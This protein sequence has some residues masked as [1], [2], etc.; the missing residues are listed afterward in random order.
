[1]KRSLLVLFVAASLATSLTARPIVIAH[2]GA[3]GYLPE[4]T[5]EAKALA[6]AMGADYI[7]QDVVLTQDGTPI[8]LHDIELDSTTDVAQR[9]PGRAREDGHYYAIDFTLAEIRQ[10]N[11]HERVDTATGQPVFPGRFG[12]A[13]IRFTI[14]TLEE[15]IAFIQRLN[16]STGRTAGLYVEIKQPA[17]HERA[18]QDI[19]RIVH[20]CLTRHG[21]DSPEAP[22][23]VQCFEPA[24]LKRLRGELGSKLR[25][26]QLIGNSG[27]PEADYDTMRTPEGLAE[28]ATYADGIG[29]SIRHIIGRDSLGLPT[30]LPLA[31]DAHAAGL[32]VHPYT[33]RRDTLP[34]GI[35]EPMLLTLLVKGARI[36]GI[37]T[38]FPDTAVLLKDEG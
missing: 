10:L 27:T 18:G 8:I 9:F 28:I 30:I 3:S 16:K 17:F 23:Y 25:L 34:P 21:Y 11:V 13:D 5:L 37:F 19:T 26:V 31:A 22:C 20:D 4:H 33:L 2:R 32:L 12:L 14:P 15:E 24:P 7:E 6:H 36:D 35:S 1:M 38:D 29:P